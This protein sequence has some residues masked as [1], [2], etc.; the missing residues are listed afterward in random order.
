MAELCEFY[1]SWLKSNFRRKNW[2]RAAVAIE[3]VRDWICY[4]LGIVLDMFFLKQQRR[5][6]KEEVDQLYC[7]KI[8]ID[9]F[10][11]HTS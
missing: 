10:Q 1:Q 6:S 9:R 3:I 5:L 4:I 2:K 8:G 7:L 11:L